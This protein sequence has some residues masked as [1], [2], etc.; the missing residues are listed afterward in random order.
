[1]FF[2]L[3]VIKHLCSQVFVSAD[4]DAE[5]FAGY[6]AGMPWPAVPFGDK[7]GPTVHNAREQARRPAA[8]PRAGKGGGW[9]R[10][11]LLYSRDA[12]CP[13]STG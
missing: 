7:G 11:V 1:M 8:R 6:H 10:R 4:R 5:S 13:I 2:Q 3:V 9:R 12:A